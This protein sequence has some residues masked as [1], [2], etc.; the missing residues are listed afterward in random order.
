MGWMLGWSFRG[1]LRGGAFDA[2]LE[3]GR[4]EHCIT[5]RLTFESATSDGLR[6]FVGISRF[7]IHV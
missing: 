2:V 7:D 3:Y 5:Y 4:G 1:I 6:S